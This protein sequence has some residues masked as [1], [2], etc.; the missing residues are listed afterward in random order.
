M[1]P[2]EQNIPGPM[3]NVHWSA[4]FSLVLSLYGPIFALFWSK[5][6][7]VWLIG[8]WPIPLIVL[9]FIGCLVSIFVAVPT[10]AFALYKAWQPG[11]RQGLF[12]AIPALL[13]ALVMLAMLLQFIFRLPS[14]WY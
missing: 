14:G 3:E 13:I 1:A 8:W 5:G 11:W 10:A 2:R 7:L 4:I 9:V 12:L 6:W